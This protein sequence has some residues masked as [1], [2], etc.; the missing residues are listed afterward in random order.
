LRDQPFTATSITNTITMNDI[1]F[2]CIGKEM[3]N[4]AISK[5]QE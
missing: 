3:F 2:G 5:Y 4:S 1:I